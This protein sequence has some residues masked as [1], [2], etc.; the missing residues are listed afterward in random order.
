MAVA[1]A[2][3]S[4]MASIHQ[5]RPRE[6]VEHRS[7][8]LPPNHVTDLRDVAK[9]VEET[10]AGVCCRYLV[11][12]FAGAGIADIDEDGYVNHLDAVERF[13][14]QYGVWK[15]PTIITW[16]TRIDRCRRAIALMHLQGHHKHVGVLHVVYGYPDP[17][18]RSFPKKVLDAFG[19]L[20]SLAK[21]TDL[22]EVRRQEIARLE[23][24]DMSE[25]AEDRRGREEPVPESPI[26][27]VMLESAKDAEI[28]ATAVRHG[29]RPEYGGD[30]ASTI[31][32]RDYYEYA[33]RVISSSD[34]LRSHI[35]TE[36]ERE[37]DETS[38]HFQVRKEATDARREVI[39]S[40]IK[41]EADQMLV[42]A[43][44]AYHASWLASG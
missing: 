6:G 44:R 28:E 19:E 3:S 8:R 23:A 16:R 2:G 37:N 7:W 12:Q 40:Q 43:S 29:F 9:G 35:D 17:F 15:H 41:V 33:L 34:A 31:R 22:V 5:L 11:D 42:T 25:R 18:T 38:E 10:N 20:A 26:H 1:I 4:F 21:Y 39:V 13:C 32:H 36:V 27:A 30:L 14:D 24:C